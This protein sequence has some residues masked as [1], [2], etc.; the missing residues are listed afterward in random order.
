MFSQKQLYANEMVG[1]QQFVGTVAGTFHLH[2]NL[3]LN[4]ASKSVLIKK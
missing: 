4:F 2:S 1:L 3:V